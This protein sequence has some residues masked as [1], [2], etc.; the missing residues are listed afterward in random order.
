MNPFQLEIIRVRSFY[1]YQNMLCVQAINMINLMIVFFATSSKIC[2]ISILIFQ[3][4]SLI[5]IS[6][7]TDNVK[8]QNK[9]SRCMLNTYRIINALLFLLFMVTFFVDKLYNLVGAHY[10]TSIIIHCTVAWHFVLDY[11]HFYDESNTP[12]LV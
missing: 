11:N 5:I 7:S 1:N 10:I 8:H 12:L 3:F 6:I 9:C 2:R 4:I